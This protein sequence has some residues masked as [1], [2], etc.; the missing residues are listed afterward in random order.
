MPD[1]DYNSIIFGVILKDKQLDLIV[2]A[3]LILA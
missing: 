2:N 3:L 1:L